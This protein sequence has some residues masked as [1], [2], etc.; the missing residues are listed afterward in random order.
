MAK[1]SNSEKFGGVVG[2]VLGCGCLIFGLAVAV[3]GVATVI[4]AV[5]RFVR[6]VWMSS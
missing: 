1:D 2:Y 4:V 3:F 6:W 5:A